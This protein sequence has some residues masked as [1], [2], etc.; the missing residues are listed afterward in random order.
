MDNPIILLVIKAI[1]IGTSWTVFY[2]YVRR[3]LNPG[4]VGEGAKKNTEKK[5]SGNADLTVWWGDAYYGGIA[6]G[7]MFLVNHFINKYVEVAYNYTFK[8]VDIITP[9]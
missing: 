1:L 9:F 4:A 8:E 2:Y 3:K 7:M 5:L 6:V